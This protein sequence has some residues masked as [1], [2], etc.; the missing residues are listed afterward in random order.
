MPPT[1]QHGAQPP[2]NR[3]IDWRKYNEWSTNEIVLVLTKIKELCSKIRLPTRKKKRGN[4]PFPT[5]SLLKCW[6]TMTFFNISSRRA[7]SF[8]REKRRR[9]GLR[10]I[11]H[12]N[13]LTTR[14]R[15]VSLDTILASLIDQ[16]RDD[17]DL[18]EEE[19][20]VDSTG[21][22]TQHGRR[23]IDEKRGAG[24][25]WAKIHTLQDVRTGL[26]LAAGTSDARMHDS[27][28]FPPLAARIPEG[29]KVLGDRAYLS[30]NNVFLVEQTKATPYIRPK[31]NTR[32][33]GDDELARIARRAKKPGFWRVYFRRNSHESRF[34][35]FK[36]IVKP[37]LRWKSRA[38]QAA[39]LL[40]AA[41]VHNLRS[42][43]RETQ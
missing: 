5:R 3:G 24:N 1:K 38:G 7:I 11:P 34:S 19:V 8:L 35:M 13:T 43:S 22:P 40:F 20:S 31:K 33:T 18:D 4:K 28:M 10:K 30:Q 26:I 23:W 25:D 29:S 12:F 15:D 17:L 27:V 16:I 39:E 21:V 32:Q 37:V 41:I 36:R 42:A 6:L 2:R 14:A 9:L